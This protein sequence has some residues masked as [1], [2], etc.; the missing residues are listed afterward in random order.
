MGKNSSSVHAKKL[1]VSDFLESPRNYYP[2]EPLLILVTERLQYDG[3]SVYRGSNFQ[4]F[5]AHAD[6]QLTITSTKVIQIHFFIEVLEMVFHQLYAVGNGFRFKKLFVLHFLILN[7]FLSFS[8]SAAVNFLSKIMFEKKARFFPCKMSNGRK[9]GEKNW[10]RYIT[11]LARGFCLASPNASNLECTV[12]SRLQIIDY[13]LH[14]L[15]E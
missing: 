14:F 9:W 3:L 7:I 8:P 15:T 1:F 11:L 13:K 5:T 6:T 10:W 2:S 4:P 12:S